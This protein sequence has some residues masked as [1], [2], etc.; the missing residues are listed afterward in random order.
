MQTRNRIVCAAAAVLLTLPLLVP[1]AR[2]DFEERRSIASGDLV[3]N[4][5]IGA[6]TI[7][8]HGGSGFDVVVRVQGRDGTRER[9]KLREGDG[10]LSVV[11]PESRD[12]VYPRLGATSRTSFT[13]DESSDQSWLAEI[14]N[15]VLGKRITV[16]GSGSGLEVWADV[17]VSVPRGGKLRLNLGVGEIEA[18]N[19]D[20]NLQLYNRAGTIGARG[21]HGGLIADTGS[22]RVVAA[23]LQ[24]DLLVDT[25]SGSV[26][27]DRCRCD[28]VDIDTGSGSVTLA[29]VEASSVRVDTGSGGVEATAVRADAADI[30]TG[31][32]SIRLE[33]ERMGRGEYRLDTGSGSITLA[34]P[35]DAAA[36]VE[37]STGNGGIDVDQGLEV[38]FRHKE[39]DEASFRIGTGGAK[40]ELDTGSGSIRIVPVD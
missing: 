9:V 37:A 7:E 26:S 34:L 27:V 20:G 35:G 23:D 12:F 36:D 31:S 28:N 25:G 22:G 24:G 10:K 33:L 13:A 19:V 2:A 39:R 21:V 3:L 18:E 6:V 38:Q 5:L 8:G 15:S 11:F 4:D 32:G 29:D 30:D 40:V 16:R 1:A 14:L 17:T